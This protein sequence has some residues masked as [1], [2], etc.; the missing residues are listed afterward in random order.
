LVNP[1]G[2][3]YPQ[4][5]R[6]AATKERSPAPAAL[7]GPLGLSKAHISPDRV[8]RVWAARGGEYVKAARSEETPEQIGG[9]KRG[10]IT[11]FSRQS[12]RRMFK[13]LA[14]LDKS[15]LWGPP[16]FIT[17]TYPGGDESDWLPYALNHKRHLDTFCKWLERRSPESFTLWRLEPQKRGAPHYHLLMFNVPHLPHE[18]LARRWW[19]VV[20]SGD[21]DHLAAGTSVEG[22]R[23]WHGAAYYVSKYLG[24]ESALEVL[25]LATP[26][27]WQHPGR[28]WGVRN[29]K[30]VPVELEV[31]EVDPNSSFYRVRRIMRGVARS[32]GYRM[33]SANS[34]TGFIAYAG[35]RRM[36]EACGARL[37]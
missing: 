16:L 12:R 33:P 24:K 29:R 2:T 32:K 37:L 27:L 22:C 5:A 14:C 6:S 11:G 23:S 7:A 1:C 13:W 25:S 10:V 21:V 36:L 3:A 19:E 17:L 30:N 9:G 28:W 8:G 15:R 18:V 4:T 26:Q 20:G 34:V 35:A 31:Y